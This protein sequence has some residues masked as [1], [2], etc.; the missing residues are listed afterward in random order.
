M[1]ELSKLQGIDIDIETMLTKLNSKCTSLVKQNEWIS[2]K[3]ALSLNSKCM[4]IQAN[5]N[6][7]TEQKIGKTVLL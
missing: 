3:A 5:T 1:F 7:S 4:A 2:S 6:A